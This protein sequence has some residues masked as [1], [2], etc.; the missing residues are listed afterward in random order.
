[1]MVWPHRVLISMPVQDASPL[2]LG[3]VTKPPK[4]LWESNDYS[5]TITLHVC[6]LKSELKHV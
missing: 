4:H 1:M 2:P 6:T 5:P 3:S